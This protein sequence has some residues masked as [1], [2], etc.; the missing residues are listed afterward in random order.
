MLWIAFK[1]SGFLGNCL[2]SV[3]H[4][5]VDSL[6][7]NIEVTLKNSKARCRDIC[8]YGIFTRVGNALKICFFH[9]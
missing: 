3:V 6:L 1:R 5:F 2:D 9:Y 7:F 4:G 8:V